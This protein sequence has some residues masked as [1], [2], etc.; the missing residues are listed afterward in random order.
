V[1]KKRET[2]TVYRRPLLGAVVQGELM[3][4]GGRRCPAC[5]A[6]REAE[7]EAGADRVDLPAETRWPHG[8]YLHVYQLI[9]G[10][11][12]LKI[13]KLYAGVMEGATIT[14]SRILAANG[15]ATAFVDGLWRLVSKGGDE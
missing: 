2:S 6:A 3:K 11:P 1:T 8:P 13:D 10:G 7:A 5:R 4:C 15:R 12:K 9:G 14:E